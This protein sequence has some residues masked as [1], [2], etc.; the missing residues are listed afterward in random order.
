[1][2]KAMDMRLY[3]IRCIIKQDQFIVYWRP[4]KYNFVDYTTKPQSPDHHIIVRP[5]YFYDPK[6]S[7]VT[8]QGCV[9]S[10]INACTA[11]VLSTPF[12]HITV[13][14]MS[15]VPKFGYNSYIRRSV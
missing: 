14:V 1:M 10:D 12:F 13:T 6:R 15:R 7:K 11:C 3:C 8:L 2:T 9:K 5:V 4:V